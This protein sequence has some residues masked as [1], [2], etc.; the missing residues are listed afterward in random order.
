MLSILVEQKVLVVNSMVMLP[1]NQ[2]KPT[3][4]S[5]EMNTCLSLS[6][7]QGKPL[8]HFLHTIDLILGGGHIVLL[9]TLMSISM[10]SHQ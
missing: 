7:Q 8:L 9:C 1:P 3:R 4:T 5:M 6:F 10:F 2:N